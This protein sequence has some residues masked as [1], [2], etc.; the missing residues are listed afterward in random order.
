[1]HRFGAVLHVEWHHGILECIV[2]NKDGMVIFILKVIVP[3]AS[4]QFLH[5]RAELK[6]GD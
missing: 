6:G 3:G 4:R 2:R 5:S 1:M